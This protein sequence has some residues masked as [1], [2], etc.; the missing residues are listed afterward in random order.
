MW[1]ER[2]D[3]M[4]PGDAA[5]IY[6]A[7]A[8]ATIP[9]RVVVTLGDARRELAVEPAATPLVERAAVA[10]AIARLE[11][12][13][14]EGKAGAARVAEIV[15][16]S[17]THR[18]LSSRTALLVL[19]TDADYA[20]FGIDRK[21]LAQILVV[22]SDGVE[23]VSRADAVLLATDA[24]IAERVDKLERKG[25][26]GDHADDGDDDVKEK[27]AAVL[28]PPAHEPA[29]ADEEEGEGHAYGT[30]GHGSGAGY[31]VGSGSG[32]VRGRVARAP[33]VR[34]GRAGASAGGAGATDDARV[35]VADPE[36]D[37]PEL[38]DTAAAA[39]NGPSA[40]DGR[41][42]TVMTLIADGKADAAL[43]EALAWRGE[44]P[45][46]VLA[47]V[48]LG[49]AFEARGELALAARAYG[50]LIDLFPARADLRRFAGERLDRVGARAGGAAAL[51]LAIDSYRR[52]VEQRP[53]HLL[54]H[55]Q[56]AFALVRAGQLEGAFAALEHGLAQR[57]SEGRFAEGERILQEDLG[58]VAAAWQR[59]APK[60]AAA[61]A[62]RLGKLRVKRAT[63]PSLR[64][65]LT[66]QTD[67]NDVDFHIRDARGGHAYYEARTLASGGELYADVTDG[68]GPECFAIAGTPTA[69]P[70]RLSI[71]YYSRGPMG[72]GMGKL[73]VIRHDGK[74]TLT[75]EER[76]FV[77]MNDG[78]FVDLGAVE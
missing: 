7:V 12:Q 2:L 78:A 48:G 67:A 68:Y 57:Y 44:Q 21:A 41:M 63:A 26:E 27:D 39:A 5:M 61:I 53:D 47:L 73:E 49:E 51:T 60:Q 4:Q 74:G 56:L 30:I 28:T 52:A 66:W 24:A 59:Q 20:R 36:P 77:V 70:Y 37:E 38:D 40:Y 45:G 42:A 50:S 72:Y 54:G 64:F 76:P 10:A 32:A 33:V 29:P 65:V 25:E 58:L 1:P 22:G 15:R 55:R 23:V 62:R 17:T 43:A 18:V 46:D 13:G 16:L 34:A 69:A 71:H 8:D 11:A 19:E 3:G 31:G 35:V 75:F 9:T 14:V 6:A